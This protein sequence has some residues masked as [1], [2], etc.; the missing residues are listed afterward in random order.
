MKNNYRVYMIVVC[1]LSMLS[2]YGQK[3]SVILQI[4]YNAT[5]QGSKCFDD[6]ECL[7]IAT[8]SSRYYSLIGEYWKSST[9]KSKTTLPKGK[10][11]NYEIYKNMPTKGVMEYIHQPF[12]ITVKDSIS[13]L[14]SWEM[15]EGDSIVCGYPCKLARTKFRGKQWT[16]WYT[17]DLPFSDGPWKLLGLPGVIL[18]ARDS[19]NQ[20]RFECI[21]I[22]KA[23]DVYITYPKQKKKYVSLQKAEELRRLEQQSPE[24]FFNLIFAGDIQIVKGS[25]KEKGT[26]PDTSS[27]ALEIIE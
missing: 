25:P 27:P 15:L 10:K 16:V 8:Y 14:F 3:D 18:Y 2:A 20:N 7:D 17:I 19:L 23:K 6:V 5:Y 24:D 4:T 1:L 21:S 12:W 22:Q 13:N 26:M 9:D 11:S